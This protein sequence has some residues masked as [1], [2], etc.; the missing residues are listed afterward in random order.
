[1]R[2]N[3]TARQMDM[4]RLDYP[5]ESF[6]HVFS[7]CVLEHLPVS[8][9]IR[10]GMEVARVL[11]PGGTASYTFDYDNPQSFG[12]LGSPLDVDLQIVRPSALATRGNPGF[13][14][15]RE[16]QLESPQC[17]GTSRVTRLMARLHAFMTGSVSR[18]AT[19]GGRMNYTFGAQF[20]EKG[21]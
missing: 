5:A 7:V 4:T 16:R 11:K 10:T 3:L 13:L 1:M 15:A 8:G 18:R 21:E 6:D 20:L 12:R 9:R 2:W 14:D 17:F 19:L